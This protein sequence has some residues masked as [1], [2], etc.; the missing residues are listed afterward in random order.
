MSNFKSVGIFDNSSFILSQKSKSLSPIIAI[1]ISEL[2][3]SVFE[4]LEP[5]RIAFYIFSFEENTS[6]IF[7]KSLSSIIFI[8]LKFYP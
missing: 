6:I 4:A 3:F 2:Y 7:F 1:S 8:F 5:K